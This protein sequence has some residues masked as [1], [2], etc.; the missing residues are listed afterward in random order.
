VKRPAP[1]VIVVLV[2]PTGVGKTDVGFHLATSLGAEIV[3]AD[4]R[5]VYRLM[6]IGTAKPDR[7]LTS[8]VPHHMI[9]LLAPDR[10]F[11]CKEYER[12]ARKAIDEIA[13][14]GKPTVVVG[15]TGL[16][17]RA[18]VRG[19]FDG[20]AA[21]PAVRGRLAEEA[22]RRG[23]RALWE[24]LARVDPEKAGQIHPTN[25]TRIVRAL[26]VQERTGKRMSDLEKEARPLD[27]PFRLVGLTRER[28]D[29]YRRIDRR[30]EE[31]FEAGLV[32]EVRQL[33]SL[34]YTDG[35]VVRKTLGYAEVLRYLEGEMAL[36]E[37]F[38]SVK[39]NTRNFAKRQITWFKQEREI[40][41]VDVTG[42]ADYQAIASEIR[43]DLGRLP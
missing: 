33:A 19:I 18:L 32:D 5:L 24:D 41:W 11:T 2:G 4:S 16:Y 35:P 31:M 9:D 25:L 12:T 8:R 13:G 43:S 22:R 42:R 20:P 6:D 17:V 27:Y 14:R 40:K 26:E 38:R 29:L 23:T 36:D 21:D 10:Q 15:G 30:V 28:Q 37:A 34:G 39:T 7:A 3:S 1:P